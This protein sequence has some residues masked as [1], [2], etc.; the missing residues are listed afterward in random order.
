MDRDTED[1][2]RWTGLRDKE[3]EHLRNRLQ[4]TSDANDELYQSLVAEIKR[5]DSSRAK[6]WDIVAR[7]TV[8]GTRQHAETIEQNLRVRIDYIA[9]F[10]DAREFSVEIVEARQ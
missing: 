7:V 8:D 4:L 1:I 10:F 9:G 6:R 5:R 3:L 2:V